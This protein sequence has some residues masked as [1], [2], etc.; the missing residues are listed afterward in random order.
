MSKL[1]KLMS[2]EGRVIDHCSSKEI[3]VRKGFHKYAC[4]GNMV[5]TASN[6]DTEKKD[7]K[8]SDGKSG[9]EKIVEFDPEFLYV[10]V[11]A[12]TANIPNNNGDLFEEKELRRTFKTF[13]NQRVFKNHKSD[14]VTNAVGRIIDAVWVDDPKDSKHSYVECLLEID[15]KKDPELVRGIEKG[16][17]SDCSMGARIEYSVC[18]CC[19]NKAHTEDE[20]CACV[21][22]YKGQHFCPEHKRKCGDEGIYESN[23]GV[24]FFELSFVTDGADKQAIVKE[25]VASSKRM[26]EMK[27]KFALVGQSLIDSNSAILQETGKM[28]KK[29]ASSEILSQKDLKVADSIVNL[30]DALLD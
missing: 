1:V 26:A 22:K 20:Y 19:G 8:P 27:V 25:V 30:V 16:Y 6:D 5:K 9:L 11:R 4:V 28:L 14:D 29:Y 24:E 15:R 3:V 10:R 13:I 2:F 7:K 21:K 12:V 18:S 17:I 23:F